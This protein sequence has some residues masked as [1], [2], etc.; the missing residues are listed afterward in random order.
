V[1]TGA[2]TKTLSTNP[3]VSFLVNH[4]GLPLARTL[5]KARTLE[6]SQDSTGLHT[7]ARLNPADPDVQ[8]ILP[9][10]ERGDMDKMSFGFRTIRDEWSDGYEQR[11]M[12]E[13][14]LAN[15][16]VSLVTNPANPH[17]SIGIR[18]RSFAESNPEQVRAAYKALREEREGKTISSATRAQLVALLESMDSINDGIEDASEEL[19]NAFDVLNGMLGV[20]VPDADDDAEEESSEGAE[21]SAPKPAMVGVHPSVVKARAALEL[22]RH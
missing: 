9:K 22:L 17:T 3:D 21:R 14:S 11:E 7:R 1:R 13:L 4:E 10:V 16:D 20:T 5:T 15:G 12:V 2:F 18:M 19:D 8:R 6:L